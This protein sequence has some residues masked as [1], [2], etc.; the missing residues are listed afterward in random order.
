MKVGRK[1]HGNVKCEKIYPA[2]D[3]SKQVSDLKTV[4]FQLDKKQ[5]IDLANTTAPSRS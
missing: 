2:L 5:A 1:S 3:T 4:V